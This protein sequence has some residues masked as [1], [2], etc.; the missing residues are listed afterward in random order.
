MHVAVQSVVLVGSRNKLV[1]RLYEFNKDLNLVVVVELYNK[2]IL[3][4][5]ITMNF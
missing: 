1:T 4:S 5:H 3:K 2:F